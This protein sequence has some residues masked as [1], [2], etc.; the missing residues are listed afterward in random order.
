VNEAVELAHRSGILSAASLMVAGAAGADAVAR[1]RQL[2]RLRVG[3]HLVLLEGRPACPPEQIPDLVDARGLLR[4]DMV[5]L[6]FDLARRPEVRRQSL[7]EISAQFEAYR[8]TGLPLDHVN[9]HKHFHLHPVIAAQILAVGRAYGMRS[10]R[11]PFEPRDV[12]AR[13]APGARRELTTP[14]ASVVRA[15]ARRAGLATADAVFGLR[16]SGAFTAERMRALLRVLPGGFNEIYLH[17]ATA[18][19]FPGSAPGYRYAEELAAL[20]DPEARELVLRSGI[21]VG[22][23]AD[24]G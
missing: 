21:A 1:A 14:W 9:T 4:S 10:L 6:A 24:R 7:R 22:G 18:D 13:A 2:P 12:V 8:A 5:R 23:Y 15:R 17:P 11:V 3:L 20:C 16:W 19:M